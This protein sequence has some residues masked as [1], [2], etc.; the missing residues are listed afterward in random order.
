MRF[1]AKVTIPLEKVDEGF[2]SGELP[3]TMQAAIQRLKPEAAYFFE[4]DGNRECIFVFNLDVATLLKPLF[5]NLGASFH[6]TPVMNSTEF[7]RE[8]AEARAEQPAA[9][10]PDLLTDV[11]PF[12]SGAPEPE[13]AQGG[14]QGRR[15]RFPAGPDDELATKR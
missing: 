12:P 3:R 1:L 5:P 15:T 4:E 13:L 11:K 8:L 6:V 2:K 14:W 10:R 7:E 9:D